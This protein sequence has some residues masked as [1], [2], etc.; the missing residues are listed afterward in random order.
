MARRGLRRRR[1]PLSA[2]GLFD[3]DRLGAFGQRARPAD[4][5][6]LSRRRADRGF[7]PGVT[8]ARRGAWRNRARSG[9]RRGA[10]ATA[11][12]TQRL[13]QLP[14]ARLRILDVRVVR[15]R[16]AGPALDRADVLARRGVRHDVRLGRG[17]S[18]RGDSAV[19]GNAARVA[20]RCDRQTRV[21]DVCDLCV[22]WRRICGADIR[23]AVRVAVDGL[24]RADAAAGD[25][26]RSG[27]SGT[28]R[29]ADRGFRRSCAR[30][31]I[32]RL[33]RVRCCRRSGGDDRG[34][35][36]QRRLVAIGGDCD[37]GPRDGHFRR[38]R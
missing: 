6:T 36:L 7:N 19:A 28:R 4:E 11:A 26:T 13:S 12:G 1:G 16:T 17:V 2:A 38:Y 5:R 29:R 3:N 33:C 32:S 18:R 23:R 34:A 24:V 9:D 31:A 30:S 10:R 8:A 25:P 21:R 35:R 20:V 15:A 22:D 37:R 14:A 27:S